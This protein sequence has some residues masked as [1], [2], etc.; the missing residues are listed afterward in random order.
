MTEKVRSLIG[1]CAAAAL[2]ALLIFLL[3]LDKGRERTMEC[4]G[5]KAVVTD[6]ARLSFISEA[7]VIANTVLFCPYAGKKACEMDL[8][9]I[10]RYLEEKSAIRDCEAYMDRQGYV[11]LVVSQR[12]PII[13][14]QKGK[15]GFYADKSGYLFPLQ[16]S[17]TSRVPIIDGDI[18]LNADEGFQ[19]RPD[20]PEAR[21]WLERIIGMVSYMEEAGWS[22]LISQVT[23]LENGDL[24]L[25]P[26]EGKER[27]IFGSPTAL[28]AKFGRIDTYYESIAP[29]GKNYTSVDVRYDKQII[30]KK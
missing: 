3:A 9:G 15:R 24:E 30:C 12:E 21:Q 17:Y 8:Q 1:I 26:A 25:I 4:R 16:S 13:R 22:S 18:P 10:E 20:D 5:V 11:N 29:A 2:L 19:G 23:V 27:F 7:A 6:S 28:K 14:F